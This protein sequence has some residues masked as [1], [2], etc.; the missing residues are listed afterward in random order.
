M[1]ATS[2]IK[3]SYISL[4]K[5]KR[6]TI[7]TLKTKGITE[8]KNIFINNIGKTGQECEVIFEQA[9][10]IYFCSEDQFTEKFIMNIGNI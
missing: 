9:Q 3:S 8:A 5:V 6:Q 1:L 4:S 10:S 2:Q 7:D